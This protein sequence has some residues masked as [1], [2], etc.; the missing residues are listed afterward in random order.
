MNADLRALLAANDGVLTLAQAHA[1]G[2]TRRQIQG[3]VKRKDWERYGRG[4]YLS[5]SHEF[6]DR[7]KVRA[8]VAAHL[9]G[10]ADRLTAAWWFGMIAPQPGSDTAPLPAPLTVC[11]P[12]TRHQAPR[13]PEEVSVLRRAI[14][15]E[16]LT[17]RH[18]LAITAK[19]LTVLAAAGLMPS[20]AGFLDRVLAQKTVTVPEL[21]RTAER[22]A[23][24]HGLRP[25]RDLLASLQEG[26][27]SEA[28]RIFVELLR[29]H[30][31]TGWV[32]QHRFGKWRLDVAWPAERVSVEINGWAYHRDSER[33]ERDNAK[34][35]ELAAAGWLP[36]SFT[37]RQLTEEPETCI[38][39]VAA[40]LALRRA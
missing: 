19:P 39:R 40:A 29:L 30:R 1:C 11:V 23:R 21:T 2:L 18:G 9:C 13:L 20:P 14:A 3:H 24:M 4:V 10:V 34:A 28:E 32:Q 33:F 37:W 36:L 5:T 12:P 8:V 26:T 6:T 38:A 7:A 22:N 25:A 27:E 31:I 16:D 17:E 15:A 35:A